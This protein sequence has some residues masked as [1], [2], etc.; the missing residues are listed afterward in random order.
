MNLICREYG[1][2]IADIHEAVIN[3]DG[4]FHRT[5]FS[6]GDPLWHILLEYSFHNISRNTLESWYKE[7]KRKEEMKNADK[8]SSLVALFESQ[9]G[10]NF[11]VS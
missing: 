10:H 3:L 11:G 5:C 8:G 7:F 4:I 9:T 2:P 6:D 1:Q